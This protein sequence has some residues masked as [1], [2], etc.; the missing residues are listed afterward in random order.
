MK[1]GEAFGYGEKQ[2]AGE[3]A[4]LSVVLALLELVRSSA[5]D[6]DMDA[7]DENVGKLAVLD[8]EDEAVSEGIAKLRQA[9]ADLDF[10]EDET[11][12]ELLFKRLS[13]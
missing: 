11:R 2:E 6:M 10:D 7:M 12:A 8:Y 5:A 9:A 13:E 3:K 4:E 1:L